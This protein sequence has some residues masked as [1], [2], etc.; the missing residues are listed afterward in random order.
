M[1]VLFGERVTTRSKCSFLSSFLQP[2]HS[3]GTKPLFYQNNADKARLFGLHKCQASRNQ[4]VSACTWKHQASLGT[5]RAEAAEARAPCTRDASSV[6][7]ITTEWFF[8]SPHGRD[9]VTSPVCVWGSFPT[10]RRPAGHQVGFVMGAASVATVPAPS[11][12][13]RAA[14]RR[15][16][17]I[18]LQEASF[19]GKT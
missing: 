2:P 14:K 16:S 19:H 5:E 13:V 11:L 9:S 8:S 3:A 7:C 15:H 1:L 12:H 6:P 18:P 4:N 17:H 10:P